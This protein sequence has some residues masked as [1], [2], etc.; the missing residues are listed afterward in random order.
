M[1]RTVSNATLANWQRLGSNN[2]KLLHRANKTDSLRKIFPDKY[3]SNKENKK[4]ILAIA[5]YIAENK[6]TPTRFICQLAVHE[7]TFSA[8]ICPANKTRFYQEALVLVPNLAQLPDSKLF[9]VD[10][11]EPDFL[12]ALY[13]TL[14]A[15]GARNKNGLYYTPADVADKLLGQMSFSSDQDFFDPAVGTGIFLI[16][17]VKKFAIPVAN[18][19]GRDIDPIAVI[20][21]TAN[22]LLQAPA[23]DDSYPDIKVSDYLKTPVVQKY[24]NIIGNPPWGAKKMTG[25]DFSKFKKA[26]SF[27]YFIEKSFQTLNTNGSLAFVLPVSILNITRHQPIRQ[28][29]LTKSLLKSI[30]YLPRLFQ[31]VVSDVVLLVLRKAER[32]NN[33]VTFINGPQQIEL[34]Q[35]TFKSL[36]HQ[37]LLPV[38][39][40]DRQILQN[41]WHTAHADLSSST[42]GLGI[43]TGNNRKFVLSE[44]TQG[45]EPLITGKEVRPFV[46]R[47]PQSYLEFLP[48]KFQQTAAESIYRSPEKL[49]YKFINNHLVFAYDNQK[50]L[51]LNSANIL[52]PK[53]PTH[54]TKTVM[55]FLNSQLFQYL[56]QILFASPKVLRGNL[57]ELPIALLSDKERKSLEKLVTQQLAGQ[58]LRKEIDKFIFAKYGLTQFQI[59]RIKQVLATNI[60]E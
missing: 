33:T 26:D 36:P 30:T 31:G 40:C 17:L 47:R 4:Q 37:N 11:Q 5:D 52:V 2:K 35:E 55:A 50:R 16:E 43:V 28:L 15:E 22:I 24:T 42:W 9:K 44:K 45:T 53:V 57:E 21:A 14:Q 18:L 32:A 46:L 56:N 29:I 3:I 6:L 8:N 1:K 23:N 34:A 20:L 49:I 38:R 12:G 60:F 7:V 54:S 41:V 27:A 39:S 25:V 48:A 19:H 51:T 13:Q 58:D 10:L 59:A